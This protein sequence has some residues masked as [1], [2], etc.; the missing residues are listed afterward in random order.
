MST[1]DFKVYVP[2]EY[3][4]E[5]ISAPPSTA[6][7]CLSWGDMVIDIRIKLSLHS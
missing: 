6:H 1:N 2:N 7:I 5:I 4:V 3:I